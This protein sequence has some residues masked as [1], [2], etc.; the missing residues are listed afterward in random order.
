MNERRRRRSQDPYRALCLQLE[1]ARSQGEL[2]AMVVATDNGL[3]VA[4]A[5]E[6]TV[7]EALGAIAPLVASPSFDGPMPGALIGQSIGVRPLYVGGETIYIA[8]AGRSDGSSWIQ[9][10]IHGV[11]RILGY[12][13]PR[14]SQLLVN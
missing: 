2:D 8:S 6:R 3:L 10:S 4:G 7:C 11:C 14:D 9:G 1:H 5:G 12:V 13:P